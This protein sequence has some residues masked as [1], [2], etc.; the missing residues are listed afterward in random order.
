MK[1]KKDLERNNVRKEIGRTI[2]FQ[3]GT[4]KIDATA[5]E[6]YEPE[7]NYMRM[8]KNTPSV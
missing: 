7:E 2:K 3:I 4:A 6:R 1:T 5:Y 8:K